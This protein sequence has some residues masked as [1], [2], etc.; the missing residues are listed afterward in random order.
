M[1]AVGSSV[2]PKSFAALETLPTQVCRGLGQLLLVQR[3]L[4]TPAAHSLHSKQQ[5]WGVQKKQSQGGNLNSSQVICYQNRGK[6]V[7]FLISTYY[8]KVAW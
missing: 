6:L 4:M 8:I 3:H 1:A 2:H 5:S 7:S